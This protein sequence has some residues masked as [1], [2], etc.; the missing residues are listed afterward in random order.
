VGP[1]SGTMD[2]RDIRN[3]LNF[4]DGCLTERGCGKAADMI[5]RSN[6][7]PL[8]AQVLQDLRRRMEAGEFHERFPTDR[9]LMAAYNVSRPTVREAVR[10][11]H[12]EGLLDRERGRGTFVRHEVVEQ[13]IGALHSLLAAMDATD[14]H[15]GDG[16]SHGD[17]PR[18]RVVRLAPTGDPSAAD[19][20]GLPPDA[21]LVVLERV[22]LRRDGTPEAV[23][24]VWMPADVG[25]PLLGVD[26]STASLTEEL[27][28]RSRVRVD[29]A[30]EQI[31]A[32]LPT[33]EVGELLAGHGGAVLVVERVGLD[34]GR[35]VTWRRTAFRGDHHAITAQWTDR[36][37]R[38]VI[39]ARI[40]G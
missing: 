6:P 22:H 28:T 27:F 19:A 30:R 18:A 23:D 33:P 10:R 17:A 25:E 34:H 8:W 36:R 26:F 2:H 4:N 9:Q 16:T 37:D 3:F 7:L 21:P 11:L 35:P 38:P 40:T 5:D 29:G 13:G 32:A 39:E 31:S 20:L 12:E 14:A 1:V 24:T 15:G